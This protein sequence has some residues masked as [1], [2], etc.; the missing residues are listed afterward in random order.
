MKIRLNGE[1]VSLNENLITV[2]ALLDIYAIDKR[3]I[4]LEKNGEIVLRKTYEETNINDGD[5]IEIIHF[6]GGG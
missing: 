2:Q 4:A 6:I 1:E 5:N 3:K